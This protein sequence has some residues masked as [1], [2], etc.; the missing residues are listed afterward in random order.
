MNR[1]LAILLGAISWLSVP[2]FPVE[3]ENPGHCAKHLLVFAHHKTGTVMGRFAT[4]S[5]NRALSASC[6]GTA[7]TPVSF[8]CEP[9]P[10]AEVAKMLMKRPDLCVLHLTRDPYEII[11]SGVKRPSSPPPAISSLT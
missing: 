4:R 8:E 7:Q 9:K 2:A 11:V 10:I 3:P 5:L 1:V 6:N